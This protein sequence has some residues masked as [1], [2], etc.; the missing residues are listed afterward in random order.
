ML[1]EAASGRTKFGKRFCFQWDPVFPHNIAYVICKDNAFMREIQS[2][3]RS[4]TKLGSSYTVLLDNSFGFLIYL[5]AEE[6]KA[7]KNRIPNFMILRWCSSDII[8]L[9]S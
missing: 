3:L 6:D 5:F 8:I 4:S 1:G 2:L 9:R 7:M